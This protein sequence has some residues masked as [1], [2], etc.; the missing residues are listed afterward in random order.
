MRLDDMTAA[1]T[2][3]PALLEV[4]PAV[5]GEPEYPTQ[6]QTDAANQVVA[7]NWATATS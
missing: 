7:Q 5:Q 2:A 4:L 6:E 1:A 3:D